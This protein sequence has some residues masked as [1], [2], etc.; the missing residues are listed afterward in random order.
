MQAAIFQWQKCLGGLFD[1]L[2]VG[3]Q[4]TDD[5]GF[6]IGGV[7]FSNSGAYSSNHGLA[8]FW[9][10]K[11]DATG[12]EQWHKCL[13]GTGIEW[14]NS[15]I[16]TSDL[17]YIMSGSTQ[18]NDG[19]V[20]GSHGMGD[21]WI[22][23]LD[24]AGNIQWQRCYGGSAGDAA[25]KIKQTSDGGYIVVGGTSSL[26]GDVVGNMYSSPDW[27]TYAMWIVKLDA[28][29]NIQWQRTIDPQVLAIKE[30]IETTSGNFLLGGYTLF[31]GAP[32]MMLDASG[33]TQ[34]LACCE[35]SGGNTVRSLIETSDGNFVAAVMHGVT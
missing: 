21:A 1:E 28:G 5:S 31:T 17:G 25:N 24:T 27:G 7:T 20:S 18:S 23:K 3:C 29:G 9:I 12:N 14:A 15:I 32:L 30:I 33:N 34:W 4:Q 19:D 11:T 16:Q 2:T 35:G 26:D 22:V 6:V 8:D 13:G 10:L